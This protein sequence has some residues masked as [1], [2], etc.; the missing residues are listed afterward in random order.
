MNI[1]LTRLLADNRLRSL[2]GVIRKAFS[3]GVQT[4]AECP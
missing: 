4:L 1:K 2:K 3:L